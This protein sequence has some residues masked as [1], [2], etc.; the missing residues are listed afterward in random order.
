VVHMIVR[1]QHGIDGI[2]VSPMLGETLTDNSKRPI[3]ARRR[4]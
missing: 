1:D 4:A 2:G 3:A